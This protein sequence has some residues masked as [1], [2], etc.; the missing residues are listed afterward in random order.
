MDSLTYWAQGPA[1]SEGC[2]I[3]SIQYYWIS[4]RAISDGLRHK[5]KTLKDYGIK[6]TLFLS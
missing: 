1:L 2:I 4:S 6:P 5:H 3:I